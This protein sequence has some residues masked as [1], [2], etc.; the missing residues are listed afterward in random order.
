MTYE[1]L[2]KT[3]E[4]KYLRL[5]KQHGVRGAKIPDGARV[6]PTKWAIENGVVGENDNRTYIKIRNM[7]TRPYSIIVR[8]EDLKHGTSYWSGFW[9]RA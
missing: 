2:A 5:W 6:V 3:D 7:P 9:K 8:R 4:K 1:S